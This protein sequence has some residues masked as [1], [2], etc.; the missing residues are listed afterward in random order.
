MLDSGACGESA[1]RPCSAL[2]QLATE[3]QLDTFCH[4]A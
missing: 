4:G 1:K 2:A 3:V